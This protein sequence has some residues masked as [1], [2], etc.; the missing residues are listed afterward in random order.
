MQ[1]EEPAVR[2]ILNPTV[3]AQTEVPRLGSPLSHCSC[4]CRAREAPRT[5]SLKSW[6]RTSA[7]TECM[8]LPTCGGKG[9]RLLSCSVQLTAFQAMHQVARCSFI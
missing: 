7:S 6:S 3:M 1:D 4:G 2:N 8:P 9:G 5:Y